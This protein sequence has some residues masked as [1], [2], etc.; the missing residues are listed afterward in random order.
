M[1]IQIIPKYYRIIDY[2][3]LIKDIVVR[4]KVSA[5]NFA[6]ASSLDKRLY[7]RFSG[8]VLLSLGKGSFVLI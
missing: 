6:C 7:K 1:R 8:L 2:K 3:I 5:A 4:L